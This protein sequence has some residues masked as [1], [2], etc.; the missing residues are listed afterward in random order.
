[1]VGRICLPWC[2]TVALVTPVVTSRVSNGTGHSN[3]SGQRDRQNFFV[4]GQRDNG[5]SSKSCL[6]KGRAG[7]VCQNPGRDMGRDNY[8]FS[9]KIRDGTIAIFFLWFSFYNIFSC[10]RTSFSAV[11]RFVPRPVPDFG[12]P[13]PSRP[14]PGF[15]CPG[16]SRPLSRFWACPVVPLS[17]DNKGTSVPLSLCPGTKK[18]WLSRC[19]EKLSCPVPL[20]TL[21]CTLCI[22]CILRI[23]YQQ[24]LVKMYERVDFNDRHLFHYSCP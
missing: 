3:F 9:V 4:P 21:I 5:T 12:C 14:V 7:T 16:P 20:E 10:F 18:F 23:V 13:G 1:M 17:R 15:G 11:S 22:Y 8:Y 2:T 6:G 24:I 19:P